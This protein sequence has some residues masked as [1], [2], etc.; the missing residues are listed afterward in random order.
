MQQTFQK[1]NNMTED[2][3]NCTIYL[4]KMQEEMQKEFYMQGNL[5]NTVAGILTAEE[6]KQRHYVK[7][8]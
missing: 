6:D 3:Q 4:K 1:L 5:Q 7:F 8:L 2:L